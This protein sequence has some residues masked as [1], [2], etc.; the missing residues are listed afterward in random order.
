MD[1]IL[2]SIKK[3]LGFEE[4][5]TVFDVDIIMHINMVLNTLTQIGVG[6]ADGFTISDSTATWQ[7]Y[8]GN[9]K[10][11][12]MVKT[13][14]YMKVKQVFDPGTSSALNNAIDNQIKELEWRI[15]VQ[16]DPGEE[17]SNE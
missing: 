4:D 14:I 8:L 16:V 2:L 10:K 17:E 9:C 1:S 15:S 11:L 12:E 6:P 7:E 3:L 13:Y 5:Y